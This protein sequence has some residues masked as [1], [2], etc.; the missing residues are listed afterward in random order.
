MGRLTHI[1]TG[2]EL[3][4]NDPDGLPLAMACNISRAKR[5]MSEVE[6]AQSLQKQKIRS[7]KSEIRN[8]FK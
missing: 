3:S 6:G 4:R 5:A 1:P 2:L 8:N 7:T